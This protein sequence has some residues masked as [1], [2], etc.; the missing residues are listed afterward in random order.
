MLIYTKYKLD[1]IVYSLSAVLSLLV[2]I[3]PVSVLANKNQQTDLSEKT[4]T[5]KASNTIQVD[6]ETT[7]RLGIK[8]EPVTRQ[9]LA[10][11]IKTT[12]QIETL[13]NQKVEVKAPVNGILVELLV[14]PGAKV[15]QGQIV[16]VLSSS[17]LAQLRVESV[18]KRAEAS[19]E[20]QQ[21]QADLQLA[22]QNYE[23]QQTIVATDLKQA[24]SQLT[25]ATERYNRD[26]EL[27]AAGAIARRQVL[28]NEAK[29]TE[30]QALVAKAASRLPVLEAQSQLKRATAAVEIAESRIRLSSAGYEARLQQLGT[31]ANTKG[32]VN[33]TAPI[34]GTVVDRAITPGET[35]TV[36]AAS[37]PLMTILNDSQVWATANIY[38]KDLNKVKLGQQVRVFITSLPNLV[39]TGRITFIGSVVEGT[40]VVP[41]KADLNN[42]SSLLKPGMFARLEILTNNTPTPILT[43]KSTAV[44]E[45]DGKQ[46]VF[47]QKDDDYGRVEV[48]LG[49]KSGS[50]VEVKNGL[51]EGEQVVTEGTTL[52]YAKSLGGSGIPTDNDDKPATQK[53]SPNTEKMQLQWWLVVPAGLGL[54]IA[55]WAG[56]QKPRAILLDNKNTKLDA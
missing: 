6:A 11:G 18:Q 5:T 39:L 29:L 53:D 38:E 50:L 36:E 41:V 33:V 22:Q 23:R 42:S 26:K 2:L 44:V 25:L 7:K 47:V 9:R 12:G 30:A 46:I 31:R 20:L 54:A 51:I 35:I 3:P 48:T 32:L 56:R 55:F 24:Q 37:K 52:L 15:K 17:E 13:P 10:V 4:E 16:A 43:I 40:R 27:L 19:S 28:E 8:V 21:T 49:Q 14:K 45:N 1:K 34:S